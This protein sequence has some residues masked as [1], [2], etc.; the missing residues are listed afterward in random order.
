MSDCFSRTAISWDGIK[1]DPKKVHA[2]SNLPQPTNKTEWQKFFGMLN[3]FG[4][5]FRIYQS[6][7]QI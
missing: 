2:I 6:N 1:A 3:Y 5:L 7:Q 4:K